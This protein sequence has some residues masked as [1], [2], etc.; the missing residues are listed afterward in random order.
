V[1]VQL[2]GRMAI[3]PNGATDGDERVGAGGRQA[4][5]VT[6]NDYQ[7][8]VIGQRGRKESLG[9]PRR[10][11]GLLQLFLRAA[12]A[13]GSPRLANVLKELMVA[14]DGELRLKVAARRH[15]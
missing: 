9:G 5:F 11:A 1:A 15:G 14:G 7:L 13:D 6:R 8:T 12:S 10:G 4:R 3:T 2:A